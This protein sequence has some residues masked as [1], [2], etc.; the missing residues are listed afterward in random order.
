MPLVLQ[1]AFGKRCILEV[2]ATCTHRVIG[3]WWS[4]SKD[5]LQ[6]CIP[7]DSNWMASS[8]SLPVKAN[9]SSDEKKIESFPR[10]AKRWSFGGF[11]RGAKS[12]LRDLFRPF[13]ASASSSLLGRENCPASHLKSAEVYCP[14]DVKIWSDLH[15]PP[16]QR[17]ICAICSVWFTPTEQIVFSFHGKCLQRHKKVNL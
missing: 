16:E 6:T 10:R 8:A 14:L 13:F 11:C 2:A 15:S 7:C 4:L 3:R 9:Y 12:F 17:C 1:I 5:S